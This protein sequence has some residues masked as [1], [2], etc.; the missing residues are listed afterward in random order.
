M[1]KRAS[2]SMK[3]DIEREQQAAED[4]AA[5]V[6]RGEEPQQP[7]RIGWTGRDG[8]FLDLVPGLILLDDARRVRRHAP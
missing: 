6:A 2:L 1:L 5:A 3:K 7:L 8:A 4:R